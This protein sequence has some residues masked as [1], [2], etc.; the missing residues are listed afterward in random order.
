[1]A[2]LENIPSGSCNQEIKKIILTLFIF[3][4]LV[5]VAH[6]E[7]T[8]TV[9]FLMNEPLTLFDLG[10]YKLNKLINEDPFINATVK[11]DT[12]SNK[13]NIGVVMYEWFVKKGAAK[14]IRNK[15]EAYNLIDSMV[16]KIRTILG[17]DYQ[18]G[19]IS[20]DNTGLEDCFRPANG[21]VIKNEPESLKEDLFKMIEISILFSGQRHNLSGKASL[22][23]TEVVFD[24]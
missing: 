1:M 24:R 16:K 11:Y 3:I 15:G 20:S 12:K 17:V 6:A 5:G 18:T 4:S 23:G 7:Q 8:T 2:V 13:I 9:K 10:I 19:K 14:P 21:R 22:K